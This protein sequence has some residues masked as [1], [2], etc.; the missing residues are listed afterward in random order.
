MADEL[1]NNAQMAALSRI[2]YLDRPIINDSAAGVCRPAS[3]LN[4]MIEYYEKNPPKDFEKSGCKDAFAIVK[5][6]PE[7]SGMKITGYENQNGK[8]GSGFVAYG[9]EKPSGDAVAVFRGTEWSSEHSKIDMTDMKDNVAGGVMPL[10]QQQKDAINFMNS[11]PPNGLGGY[12]NVDV[13]GHSKGG[14][15]A[16]TVTMFDQRIGKCTT[17]NAQGFSG[18]FVSVFEPFIAMNKDKISAYNT[19]KD[20]VSTLPLLKHIAPPKTIFTQNGEPHGM[21]NFTS[22]YRNLTKSNPAHGGGGGGG[23]RGGMTLKVDLNALRIALDSFRSKRQAL[24]RLMQ[25]IKTH[26]EIIAKV[27][28]ISITARLYL[29]QFLLLYRQLEEA[30]LIVDEY[31]YDLNFMIEHYTKVEERII[32]K[33]SSLRTDVFGV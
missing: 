1:R 23:S 5:S 10:S 21:Q 13:A 16:Q 22:Y 26:N 32:N 30:L 15:L 28:W 31:I 29:K 6:D 18:A 9:F 33:V 4:E 12:K 14:N 2:A 17:F 20:Y 11:K 3:T 24:I 25:Q 27:S 8:G 7:L 19:E